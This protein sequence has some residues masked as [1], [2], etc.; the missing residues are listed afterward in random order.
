MAGGEFG[1]K[2]ALAPSSMEVAMEGGCLSRL[3]LGFL[4][5]FRR[6]PVLLIV[7][8]STEGS[9]SSRL[10]L[11]DSEEEEEGIESDEVL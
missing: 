10:L 11:F 9:G 4:A 8:G 7:L 3:D 6:E 5:V 1:E 2:A